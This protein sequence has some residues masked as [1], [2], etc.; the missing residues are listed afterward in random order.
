MYCHLFTI[1]AEIVAGENH[2]R[3]APLPI[4]MEFY[5]PPPNK[6]E[7]VKLLQLINN[8]CRIWLQNCPQQENIWFS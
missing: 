8:E 2:S 6:K 7:M 3:F 1:R 4:S 5:P